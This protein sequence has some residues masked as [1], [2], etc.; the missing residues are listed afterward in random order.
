MADSIDFGELKNDNNLVQA[1]ANFEKNLD[2]IEKSL[3]T[4]VEFK[5]FDELSTQEKVKFDNYLAY[6]VNSLFWMYVK[7]QGLDPNEVRIRFLY[8]W[9]LN[10]VDK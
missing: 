10:L 6:S 1:V 7:L 9:S 4:A 8:Q 3:N 2:K 5:D